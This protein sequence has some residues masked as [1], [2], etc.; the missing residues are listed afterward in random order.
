MALSAGT[1]RTVACALVGLGALLIVAALMIP[2]YTLG[3]LAKTPLDLEITTIAPSDTNAPSKVLDIKSLSGTGAVKVNSN[4]HLISQRYLTVEDPSDKTEMT[5]QA[6]Q[7]LRN[8]DAQGET[9]LLSAVIDRV[10][11]DR[12]TGMP[13][14]DDPNGSIAVN[15]DSNGNSIADPIQHDG[16]QY[17]FPIGTDK[18]TYPYFDINARKSFDMN[19]VEQTE[20][21]DL[22]V[23]HFQQ[24]IPATD[25]S[26]VVSS[27]SNQVALP[28]SKW[29]IPGG[30]TTVTMDRYYTNTRDV[31]VEPETGTIIK[32]SEQIHMYYARSGDKPDV[33]ALQS[34]LVFDDNTVNSQ[35]AIAKDNM[36]K[37]SLYGRTL[38][39]ILGIVGAVLLIVGLV[40]G[41]RG[42]GSE[43]PGRLVRPK[44][45]K[46]GEAA[47]ARFGSGVNLND[48][49]TTQLKMP[50][51]G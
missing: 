25:L 31:W 35:I 32:G 2:T 46:G 18:K 26:K 49:P 42:G 3:Q 50:R 28:A 17:R 21:N 48:Q 44:S 8:I 16:L 12:K 20:I 39:I 41:L 10:T 13:V 22:K 36:D 33:T 5:I 40:F 29:G 37:I 47:E 11:I 43:K 45:P 27:T 23:Y 7:T 30:D 1:R 6:G 14:E 24:K 51:N 15:T 34:T 9:G 38:P 4:V 19:F